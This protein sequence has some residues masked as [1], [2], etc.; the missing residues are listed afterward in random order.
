M[1]GVP[2]MIITRLIWMMTLYPPKSLKLEYA[3]YSFILVTV[4]MCVC[5]YFTYIIMLCGKEYDS[6]SHQL[7]GVLFLHIL[8]DSFVVVVVVVV[9]VDREGG[10]SDLG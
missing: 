10:N 7:L 4:G 3:Y 5:V 9:V 2:N 1:F 6:Q 8:L